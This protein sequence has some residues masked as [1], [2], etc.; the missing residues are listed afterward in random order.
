MLVMSLGVVV[1]GIVG[2]KFIVV[3]DEVQFGGIEVIECMEGE[4]VWYFIDVGDVVVEK[5]VEQI[6]GEGC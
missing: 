5:L 6:V 2:I 3:I 1:S 4:V